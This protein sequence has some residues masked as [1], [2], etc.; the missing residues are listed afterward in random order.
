MGI[1][2]PDNIVMNCLANTQCHAL[3]RKTKQLIT[4]VYGYRWSCN[5]FTC[6]AV[7]TG[8]SSQPSFKV[9][10]SLSAYTMTLPQELLDKIVDELHDEFS[11]LSVC[12][13]S[14]SRL[15]RRAT[16][17]LFSDIT[18]TPSNYQKFIELTFRSPYLTR[19]VRTLRLFGGK[20][21]GHQYLVTANDLPPLLHRLD[22]VR[23]LHVHSAFLGR[24]LVDRNPAL[25][26]ALLT[27][28]LHNLHLDQVFFSDT[29]ELLDAVASFPALRRLHIGTLL[30]APF[31]STLPTARVLN[32]TALSVD[33]DK[34]GRLMHTLLS[35]P[36]GNNLRTLTINGCTAY[37]VATVNGL[38]VR[39]PSLRKL[40]VG[41]S[42]LCTSFQRTFWMGES[43]GHGQ[44]LEVG[45]VKE[46]EISVSDFHTQLQW[47]VDAFR[48]A[49]YSNVEAKLET[50]VIRVDMQ[51]EEAKMGRS[52]SRSWF[53]PGRWRALDEALSKLPSL[54]RVT[55]EVDELMRESFQ[56]VVVRECQELGKRCCLDVRNWSMWSAFSSRQLWSYLLT[57]IDYRR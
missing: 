17:H 4:I 13:L 44:A 31:P 43:V 5:V 32:L 35:S 3:R 36:L 24:S 26:R 37:D 9:S 28:P 56:D 1:L 27:L 51:L 19:Y 54:A 41:K 52:R 33:L 30:S 7:G 40:V 48:G 53:Q 38:L 25:Q 42:Q 23:D 22:N 6:C 55:L 47:W 50:V 34:N 39:C 45:R 2:W 11:A 10:E 12:A 49:R 20:L 29:E 18:L 46:L 15:H 57:R 21:D 8:R 16:L 14:S